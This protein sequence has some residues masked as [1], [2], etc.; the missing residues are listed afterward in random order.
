MDLPFSCVEITFSQNMNDNENLIR[1]LFVYLLKK[2]I[3]V[4]EDEE[5]AEKR[6]TIIFLL[7]DL[8]QN[9]TTV[10][11]VFSYGLIP[12][13]IDSHLTLFCAFQANTK[14]FGKYYKIY[15]RTATVAIIRGRRSQ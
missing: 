8:S 5:N 9:E 6:L 3:E 2:F 12:C 14:K 11:L 10:R 13:S 15:R 1:C 4:S 7:T